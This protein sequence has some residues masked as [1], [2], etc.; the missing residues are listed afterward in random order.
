M[1]SIPVKFPFNPALIAITLTSPYFSKLPSVG[2]MM[3]PIIFDNV[4]LPEPLIP[5]SPITSPS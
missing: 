3:P 2:G 4:D 5:T 1:F